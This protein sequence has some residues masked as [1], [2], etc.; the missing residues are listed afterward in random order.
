[1]LPDRRLVAA[2]A[3][4]GFFGVALGAFAAHRLK[5]VGEPLD[6]WRTGS[7]YHLIHALAA[8]LAALLGSRRAGWAFVLGAIVFAGSLYAM[9]LTNV[10]TLGAVAPLGGA[11]F[12]AGW[13]M[14]AYDALK[15]RPV[16][17]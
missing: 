2:A 12:L 8:L 9:A 13:A 11:L 4:L 10:R 14:L 17:A 6:W 7:Q 16:A 3:I 5:L 15:A 1:M